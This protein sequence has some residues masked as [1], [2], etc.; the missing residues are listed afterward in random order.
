MLFRSV[1]ELADQQ[2]PGRL[3]GELNDLIWPRLPD[4]SLVT[5]VLAVIDPVEDTMSWCSAGHPPALLVTDGRQVR[6][7]ED[8]D[9]PC[10][11]FPD[12]RFRTHNERFAPGDLLFLHT[13]G[14][15]EARRGGL[16]FGERGVH[17]AL[18]EAVEEPPNTL[19]RSVY[20]AAR[21]WCEG[22]LNDDVAIAVVRRGGSPSSPGI[23]AV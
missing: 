17:Q 7:L 8:P 1:V 12:S 23:R 19:A 6:P 16:E 22:R 20:A 11:A 21:V 10:G 9:P 4:A 3:V 18:L 15:I 13:D 2:D 14:L 5:M